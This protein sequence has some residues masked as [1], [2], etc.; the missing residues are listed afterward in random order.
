LAFAAIDESNNQPLDR[1]AG[2]I[3]ERGLVSQRKDKPE[4]DLNTIVFQY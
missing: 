2:E 3:Y 1:Q 4:D